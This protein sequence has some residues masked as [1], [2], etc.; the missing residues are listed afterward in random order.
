M[1]IPLAITLLPTP[2]ITL[3]LIHVSCRESR[4][5]AALGERVEGK[6]VTQQRLKQ[7]EVGDSLVL[8]HMLVSS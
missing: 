6:R 4:R 3:I 2:A 7:A 5:L 8:L 1:N